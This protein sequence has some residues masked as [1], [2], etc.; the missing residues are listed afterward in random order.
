MRADELL[1]LTNEE[2]FELI[3]PGQV[4]REEFVC[5]IE[6]RRERTWFNILLLI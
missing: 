2:V 6:S 1:A 3:L 5:F 4:S